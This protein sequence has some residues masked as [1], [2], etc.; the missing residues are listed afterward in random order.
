MQQKL[1]AR[2]VVFLK[3]LTKQ[4]WQTHTLTIVM[5]D[6]NNKVVKSIEVSATIFCIYMA[7]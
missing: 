1:H 5:E 3:H 4:F 7:T 2:S 6:K